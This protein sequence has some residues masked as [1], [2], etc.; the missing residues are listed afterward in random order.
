[1]L[2]EDETEATAESEEEEEEE[3]EENGVHL[4]FPPVPVANV[5]LF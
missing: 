2:E 3:E 1:M 4:L 5:V